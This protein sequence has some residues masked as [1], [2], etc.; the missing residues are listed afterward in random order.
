MQALMNLVESE[1][2]MFKQNYKDLV[3]GVRKVIEKKM[4]FNGI[5]ETAIESLI[6]MIERLPNFA[7][8]DTETLK[9]ILVAIFY[10]MVVTVEQPDDDWA[11]PKEGRVFKL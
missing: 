7:A 9:E 8:K 6:V 1:P 10:Y 11:S 3:E 5:K 4:D 2:K